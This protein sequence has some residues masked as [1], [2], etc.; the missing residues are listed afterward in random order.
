M[1][2]GFTRNV[3]GHQKCEAWKN[4]DKNDKNLEQNKN[5]RS[6]QVITEPAPTFVNENSIEESEGR[7]SPIPAEDSIDLTSAAKNETTKVRKISTVN[8]M[9][10]NR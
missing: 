4:I 3:M 2:K 10:T 6:S 9:R 5:A 1:K 8:G 7:L